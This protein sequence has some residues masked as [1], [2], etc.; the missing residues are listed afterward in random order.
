MGLGPIPKLQFLYI[1]LWLL[2]LDKFKEIKTLKSLVF[3]F[4]T[5]KKTVLH[6]YFFCSFKL[7]H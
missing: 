6:F 2:K 5:F 1:I 3:L 4:P 7:Y